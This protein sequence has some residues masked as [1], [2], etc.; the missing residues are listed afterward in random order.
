MQYTA[1]CCY[2]EQQHGAAARAASLR[3]ITNK[4]AA[5][6]SG[7]ASSFVYKYLLIDDQRHKNEILSIRYVLDS[8]YLA[9]AAER[10]RP[11][12][13]LD[14]LSVVVIAGTS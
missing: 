6:L 3:S 8:V 13:D 7:A 5:S 10:R 14:F 12:A 1:V 2:R 4:R 11:R 9:V